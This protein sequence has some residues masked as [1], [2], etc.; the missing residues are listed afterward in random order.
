MLYMDLIVSSSQRCEVVSF[1]QPLTNVANSKK[2]IPFLKTYA[3]LHIVDFSNFLIWIDYFLAQI[4]NSTA[5]RTQNTT[6][7]TETTQP[8]WKSRRRLLKLMRHGLVWA[9][10]ET[11]VKRWWILNKIGR[12]NQDTIMFLWVAR[13]WVC[14]KRVVFYLTNIN[15]ISD[16]KE[17]KKKNIGFTWASINE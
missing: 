16:R 2:K 3:L 5:K 4:E 14:K 1:I 11:I 6:N 12:S 9:T 7:P 13:V 8:K 17:N 10:H 15:I